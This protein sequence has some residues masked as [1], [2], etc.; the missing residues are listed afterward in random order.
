M[1][2]TLT[3]VFGGQAIQVETVAFDIESSRSITRGWGYFSLD[4]SGRVVNNI[5]GNYFGFAI[6]HETPDDPEV[7]SLQ[8]PLPGNE[9]MDVTM[10]VLGDEFT[11]SSRRWEGYTSHDDRPRTYTRMK[12][13]AHYVEGDS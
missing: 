5:Y 3:P 4:R 8:G 6:L 12:R 1:Q 9:V 7:L 10:N 11:L 13:V 2:F